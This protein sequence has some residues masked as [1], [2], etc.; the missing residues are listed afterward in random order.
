LIWLFIKKKVIY[1]YFTN[2]FNLLITINFYLKKKKKEKQKKK[3][4]K[5][6]IKKKKKKRKKKK[7]KKKKSI[8]NEIKKFI[9][10]FILIIK[11]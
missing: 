1:I 6:K 11:I 10:I 7:K 2:F 9:Y 8:Y 5:N 3:K 4:K